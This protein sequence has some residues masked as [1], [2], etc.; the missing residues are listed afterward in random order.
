MRKMLV[1]GCL[2]ALLAGAA[3]AGDMAEGGD[4][5]AAMMAEMAGC[6]VCKHMM[7]HMESL[8]PVMTMDLAQL[9]DG[10][11]MMH[12][13]SDPAKLE[14]YRSV[15]AE[16]AKAGESCMAFSDEEASANLCSMC[17]EIRGA[18][19]AGARLSM[20]DTAMGDM[21]VIT[22]EDPAVQKQISAMAEK[23]AMM[24]ESM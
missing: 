13:V 22:S 16:M 19:H 5:K 20:G 17:Q 21:M 3:V 2:T 23:C 15:S 6:H 8:G 12:G 4:P 14:E 11:A 9:N 7:S 1:A 18:V 24:M 10:V